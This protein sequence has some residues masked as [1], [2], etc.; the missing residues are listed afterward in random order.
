MPHIVEKF[1][2]GP[3]TYN[4]GTNTVLGGR[5]VIP[6]ATAADGTI[7]HA[8]ADG[9]L[10]AIGV[11]LD[12]AEPL[13]G[14]T[15]SGSNVTAAIVRPEVA[16]AHQGVY[17]LEFAGAVGFGDLVVAAADGRV[18]ARAAETFEAVVG[19]CIEPEGVAA[20]GTRGKVRVSVI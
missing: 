9:V 19:K 20:A 18:Q 14:Q 17:R 16:V 6:D 5:V 15:T 2:G 4:V 3:V 8:N 7:M 12:D 1:N 13:A 11:A 10:N